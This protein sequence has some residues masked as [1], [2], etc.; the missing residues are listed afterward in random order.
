MIDNEK[1]WALPFAATGTRL[2]GDML[3]WMTMVN[4][5]E[6]SNIIARD[7]VIFWQ[8]NCCDEGTFGILRKS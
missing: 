6:F 3:T 1:L 2:E 5:A 4:L 7:L 8:W